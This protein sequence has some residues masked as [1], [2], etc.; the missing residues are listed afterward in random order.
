MTSHY[1]HRKYWSNLFFIQVTI[2][3]TWKIT[4]SLSFPL[5]IAAH[6]S[7]QDSDPSQFRPDSHVSKS[8]ILAPKGDLPSIIKHKNGKTSLKIMFQDKERDHSTLQECLDV[9]LDELNNEKSQPHP[10]TIMVL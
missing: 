7:L 10:L 4:S 6:T 8:V 2:F 5:S 9:S 3:G 1:E